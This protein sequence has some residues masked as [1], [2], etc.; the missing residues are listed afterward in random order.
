MPLVDEYIAQRAVGE[1]PSRSLEMLVRKS[2][3]RERGE[4]HAL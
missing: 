2:G 1:A 3:K 4:Q